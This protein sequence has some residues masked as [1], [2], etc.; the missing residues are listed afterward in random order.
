MVILTPSKLEEFGYVYPDF[1]KYFYGKLNVTSDGNVSTLVKETK[2]LQ[3]QEQF[4]IC[5][6]I[7][8]PGVRLC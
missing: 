4:G 8:S 6:D 3:T 7:P 2:I 1:V 5:L